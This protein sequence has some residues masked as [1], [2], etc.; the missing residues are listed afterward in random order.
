MSSVLYSFSNC[1][2]QGT[3]IGINWFSSL[4]SLHITMQKLKTRGLE[5]GKEGGE[6]ET[7]SG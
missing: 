2:E 7:A 4:T 5:G 3:W 6:V 1:Y